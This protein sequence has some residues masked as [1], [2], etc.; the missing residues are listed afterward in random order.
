MAADA[1][2]VALQANFCQVHLQEPGPGGVQRL[3]CIRRTRLGKRGEQICVGDWVRVEAIDWLARRGAIVELG[4]RQSLLARPAV[5]NCSRIV[6]VVS[7]AQPALDPLQLTRFLITAERSAQPVEVVF[8]KADLVPTEQ[9]ESWVRRLEGWGYAA[10]AVSSP[11]GLGLSELAA[12][13]S[14][15]GLSVLCGPSG[16]GKSSLL[17]ALVPALQ[18]RVAAVSGR[19]QRGRHTTRHVELFPLAEGALVADSPGFNRPDLPRDPLALGS[20]FP[21]IRRA[22]ALQPCRFNNCLHQGEP[23]CTVGANWDRFGLYSH[24]LENLL[25]RVEGPRDRPV[26]GTQWP[27][28]SRRLQRQQ[29][30]EEVDQE[31]GDISLRNPAG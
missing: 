10:L 4:E 27:G 16:V 21:E 14:S 13:L 1:R 11:S 12:Q 24:C 30:Q 7:L 9:R 8:S 23:G 25:A 29:L 31:D 26:P 6:V 2:V 15:P 19:L 3:L 5:A 22:Q 18:L 28:A 20:L 17:N